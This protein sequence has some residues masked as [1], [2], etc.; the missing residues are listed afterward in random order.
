MVG[1]IVSGILAYCGVVYTIQYYKV[2]NKRKGRLSI[3]PFLTSERLDN[4]NDKDNNEDDE[5]YMI[6]R[7]KLKNS[8][9][10][11]IIW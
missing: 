11:F 5:N 8:G 3:H 10:S 7:V 9:A 2:S 4:P 1:G 6:L